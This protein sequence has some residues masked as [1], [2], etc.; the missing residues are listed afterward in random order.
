MQCPV[1]APFPGIG[2]EATLTYSRVEEDIGYFYTAGIASAR[3]D[4]DIVTVTVVPTFDDTPTMLL[5]RVI[6]ELLATR[7]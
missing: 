2:D 3:I 1:C 5:R 4:N 6:A 7:K